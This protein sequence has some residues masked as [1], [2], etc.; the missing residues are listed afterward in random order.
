MHLVWRVVD[1]RAWAHAFES[2]ELLVPGVQVDE[3]DVGDDA[4]TVD[5][6]FGGAGCEDGDGQVD[7]GGGHVLVPVDVLLPVE[8]LLRVL[9][10]A[11]RFLFAFPPFAHAFG[12][13]AVVF[14]DFGFGD[15]GRFDDAADADADR[16]GSA[17]GADFEEFG[18]PLVAG[19]LDEV[20][21]EVAGLGE[22]YGGGVLAWD[23]P[24]GA[25]DALVVQVFR[26]GCGHGVG[27]QVQVVGF[28]DDG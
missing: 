7:D 9:H 5:G 6:L 22:A 27:E 11:G 20:A 14:A 12:D 19:L 28:R 1:R 15:L 26:R 2:H 21:V 24:F 25:W 10:V 8:V 3:V 23:V 13:G 16:V 17:A 18:D 4:E